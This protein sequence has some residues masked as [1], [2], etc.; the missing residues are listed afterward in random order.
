LR[1]SPHDIEEPEKKETIKRSS[2]KKA[3][4]KQDDSDS[5]IPWNI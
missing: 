5:D 3:A 1:I 4:E 2:K